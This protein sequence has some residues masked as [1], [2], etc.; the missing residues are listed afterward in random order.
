MHNV[1]DTAI[2]LAHA[3]EDV[4]LRHELVGRPELFIQ[5]NATMFRI[6]ADSPVTTNDRSL[7]SPMA[8]HV[9]E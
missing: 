8:D 5:P 1:Q 3:P 6:V 2:R 7:D 4:G 9:G